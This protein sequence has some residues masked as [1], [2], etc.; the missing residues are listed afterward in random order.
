MPFATCK[1]YDIRLLRVNTSTGGGIG[2]RVGR[3][4]FRNVRKLPKQ[5]Y[6]MIIHSSPES[7]EHYLPQQRKQANER[8]KE[9]KNV[10]FNVALSKGAVFINAS[11]TEKN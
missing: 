9:T 5:Q 11:L 1:Q 3:R 4:C 7:K 2:G 8:I 10:L 6:S